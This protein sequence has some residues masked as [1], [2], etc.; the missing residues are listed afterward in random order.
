MMKY[1]WLLLGSNAC[2]AVVCWFLFHG[3]DGS[4]KPSPPVARAAENG[5]SASRERPSVSG[6]DRA[7]GKF[8]GAARADDSG[9]LANE[10]EAPD[11]P[12]MDP[13]DYINESGNLSS[14]LMSD[15][16]LTLGQFKAAQAAMSSHW[17]AMARR[18]QPSTA[19]ERAR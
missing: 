19:A 12:A 7:A 10:E 4:G 8:A 13:Q 3:A 5:V 18:S 2:T 15:F 16:G 17:V 14:R 9:Q 6:H 1:L 11:A